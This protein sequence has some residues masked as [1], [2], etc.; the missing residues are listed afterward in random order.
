MYNLPDLKPD[1]VLV[2]LR[3]SRT[4]DPTLSVADVLSKHEH[5]LSEWMDAH[6]GG[7]APECNRFREVISGETIEARP[8]MQRV[9]RLCEQTKYRALLVVEPQRLSRGDLQEIG[10]LTKVL[11]YTRTIVIT[12]QFSYDLE[13]SRDRESF[14][15]ELMRGN[16]YLEYQKRILANGRRVA[17]ERGYFVG[18]HPPYGYRRMQ[19]QDGKRRAFIL[20]PDEFEAGIVRQIFEMYLA[21]VENDSICKWLDTVAPKTSGGREWCYSDI[22][23]T[24]RNEHYIGL[25]RWETHHTQ[26][27]VVDG[28]LKSHRRK[29]E[30]AKLYPGRHE[31]IITEDIWRRAQEKIGT[32]PRK[33]YEYHLQN[34]FAGLAFCAECGASMV[35]RGNSHKTSKHRKRDYLRCA[36]YSRCV[37]V[38]C[39]VD[40]L[41][42]AVIDALSQELASFE[43]A[44]ESSNDEFSS[45]EHRLSLLRSRLKDLENLE[46]KQW[47]KFT[48]EDM[49]RAIFD[50]L[51]S[52]TVAQKESVA[53]EIEKLEAQG[54]P[55]SRGAVIAS[56]ETALAALQDPSVSADKKNDF[57]KACIS[58]I[59]YHRVSKDEPPRFSVELKV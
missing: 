55:E 13:D 29:S 22:Y 45:Y 41:Q 18:N 51:N 15:R 57:L 34:P 35:R 23:R 52:D 54:P 46:L 5:M 50:R 10:Y 28:V 27:E 36:R 20:V 24:L 21:D 4:D 9:L 42:D 56:L 58:K 12:L 40:D 47:D 31:P 8:E 38:G 2:Y 59:V 7:Q 49:P 6:I 43:V 1:E 26:T 19:V 14:E 17:A 25:I 3:K 48:R 30:G 11:R 53:A 37:T 32:V 44:V 39:C 16:D 33:S